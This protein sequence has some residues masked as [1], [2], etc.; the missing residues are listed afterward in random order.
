MTQFK[1][2]GNGLVTVDVSVVQVIQQPPALTHH[3]QQPATRTVVF[4]AVLQVL[5]QM[6]DALGQQS[7]LH[8]G[9]T[10]VLLVQLELFN[11]FGFR[12]Q[13]FGGFVA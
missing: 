11:R 13:T 3:H 5:G 4:L 12:F 10:G 7:N 8:V 6:V 1:F 2:L 9:R